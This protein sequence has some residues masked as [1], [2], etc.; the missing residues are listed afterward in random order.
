M[1]SDFEK[2]MRENKSYFDSSQPDDG[3]LDRFIQ[4]LN[5]ASQD[6]RKERFMLIFSKVA[7]VSLL[8]LA[9]SFVTYSL[10]STKD[11]IAENSLV[12]NI[13]LPDELNQVLAYYDATSATL[14]DSIAQ[15]AVDTTEGNKIKNMVQN[16]FSELDANIAAIE[17]EYQKNPENQALSAALINNKRK[18]AEL[19]EQVV[20]QLDISNKGFF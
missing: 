11:I 13:Q 16:Q 6:K 15:Y 9:I 20:R 17:K 7:A 19:V 18:K 12:T 1:N 5:K 4:K 10:L 3:H 8:L 2:R 14:L